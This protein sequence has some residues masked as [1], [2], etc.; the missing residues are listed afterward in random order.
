MMLLSTLKRASWVNG[1]ADDSGTIGV[2]A[3]LAGVT[4]PK[5]MRATGLTSAYCWKI[6]AQ[7]AKSLIYVL[8]GIGE[9]CNGAASGQIGKSCSPAGGRACAAPLG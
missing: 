6:R 2:I 3:R 5:M 7:G 8:G 4:L 9:V 1:S